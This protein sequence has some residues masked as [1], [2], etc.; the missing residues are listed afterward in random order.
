MQTILPT[1]CWTR[2]PFARGSV[3][4]LLVHANITQIST[5]VES[6]GKAF[7]DQA[8]RLRE[9]NAAMP[10]GNAL[11]QQRLGL[12]LRDQGELPAA[13]AAFEAAEAARL[14]ALS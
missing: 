9:A 7:G 1:C 8:R 11:I 6:T 10:G 4:D 14:S 2:T 13:L 12:L 5:C 3:F